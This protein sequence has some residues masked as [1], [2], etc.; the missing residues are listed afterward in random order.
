MRDI[1]KKKVT[2]IIDQFEISPKEAFQ[3][4]L[5][6]GC[7]I[8]ANQEDYFWEWFKG[9][10]NDELLD[11][12][13]KNK[14][15]FERLQQ[16]YH[17]YHLK[18][19][20]E[21][22]REECLA[23]LL[24]LK[25]DQTTLIKSLFLCLELGDC[26]PPQNNW[27]KYSEESLS[28]IKKLLGWILPKLSKSNLSSYSKELV[29]LCNDLIK[30]QVD[31]DLLSEFVDA[32]VWANFELAKDENGLGCILKLPEQEKKIENLYILNE[33]KTAIKLDYYRK[34]SHS[35]ISEESHFKKVDPTL[36][37][38]EGLATLYIS[39]GELISQPEGTTHIKVKP[40]FLENLDDENPEKR[41]N[42]VTQMMEL[43]HEQNFHHQYRQALAII[44]NPNDEID[45]HKLHLE[46]GEDVLVSLFQ[47]ICAMSCLIARADV[48]RYLADFPNGSLKAIKRQL[49]NKCQLENKELSKDQLDD[50]INAIILQSFEEI[51]KMEEVTTFIIVSHET[52]KSW[53]RKIEDL[54]SL[55]EK[56][57]SAILKLFSESSKESPIPFNPIYKSGDDYFYSYRSCNPQFNLNHKLYDYYI[58]DKLFNNYNKKVEEHKP[59]GLSHH[60][61]EMDFCNS[62][63]VLLEKFTPFVKSNLKYGDVENSSSFGDLDGEIDVVAYF[64]KENIIIPIQVKLSNVTPRSEKRK[65]M[66]VAENIEKKGL[67]QVAKD[68]KLLSFKEG[69]SFVAQKLKYKSK[70]DEPL[71]Y[72]IIVTDNFFADHLTISHEGILVKSISYFE[73]KNLLLNHKIHSDQKD[74]MPFTEE[75]V[76]TSLI[77]AI[78]ENI[79]WSFLDDR[80]EKFTLNKSLNL[81]AQENGIKMVI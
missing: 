22:M 47:L 21:E 11:L 73:L 19:I 79:F 59:I 66:W 68:I 24:Q 10:G 30:I 40:D 58:S 77:K 76:A 78:D 74:W 14:S 49:I 64:E 61:R 37:T 39:G 3:M 6:C 51:D 45:I 70:I 80:A 26:S 20:Y 38:N 56:E 52:L 31:I 75:N 65:Q 13:E 34:G 42:A 36:K 46:I 35:S 7:L 23:S 25:P 5:D 27:T 41:D 54:K 33:L 17:F 81:V 9:M 48:F 69:L 32:H 67:R 4:L 8:N 43:M 53:L 18:K 1:S 2:D 50:Q 29:E 55:S 57:L 15:I 12:R 28:T 44:Y 60:K 62:I 16:L 71:I 72:P 63:K